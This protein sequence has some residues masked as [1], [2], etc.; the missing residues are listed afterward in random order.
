ML[1]NTW[2]LYNVSGFEFVWE[3]A[4]IK[5]SPDTMYLSHNGLIRER[6]YTIQQY[7]NHSG[8]INMKNVSACADQFQQS[9]F[10]SFELNLINLLY[11]QLVTC[12]NYQITSS[13]LCLYFNDKNYMF[14]PIA[15]AKL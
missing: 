15:V 2:K 10:K 3:N 8:K 5:F 11:D 7:G 9:E 6:E 14:Y 4:I 13:Q 12:A 1:F